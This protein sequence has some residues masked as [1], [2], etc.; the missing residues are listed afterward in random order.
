MAACRVGDH[1]SSTVPQT[2]NFPG[3]WIVEVFLSL[4]PYHV[5]ETYK[6]TGKSVPFR[7]PHGQGNL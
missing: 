4:K 6:G 7:L 3:D 5:A 1:D 2:D